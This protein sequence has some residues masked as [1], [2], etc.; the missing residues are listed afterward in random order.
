[1]RHNPTAL[2]V[3][4]P[5]WADAKKE[6]FIEFAI[7]AEELGYDSIWVPEMWGRDAFS[8]MTLLSIHTLKI[9]I[10]SGVVSVFSRTP[11]A[12]ASAIA[13]IDEISGG[14]VILGLG[15]SGPAVI[16]NWHGVQFEQPLE[17]TKEYVQIIRLILSGSKANYVGKVFKLKDFRLMF[18]PI[19]KEI[20]IFIASLGPKNVRMTAEI[21]D[22]WIPY[23]VPIES[24]KK[25]AESELFD[26]LRIA[27]RT[28]R[29]FRIAPYFPACVS[30]DPE[31]SKRVV[32]DLIAY[33]VGGMGTYYARSLSRWGFEEEAKTI[34]DAWSSGNKS[35][36][37]QGV[38]SNL[39]STV[40]I[41]GT[42]AEA[43]GKLEEIRSLGTFVLPILLFPPKATRKMVLDT[44]TALAPSHKKN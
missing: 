10:A 4:T 43:L 19:R 41:A 38:T 26:P 16:E 35:K 6:E 37:A 17:R 29:E 20:P 36:A 14:R 44:M 30:D 24:I 13:T 32:R 40:A 18:E 27:G 31:E 34:R 22:G 39:L 25:I 1:M 7:M 12:I 9:G 5:L 28:E 15:T 33:Y 23:L 42:R 2:G 11:A 3:V 8:I 21:A